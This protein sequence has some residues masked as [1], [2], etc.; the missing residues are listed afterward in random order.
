[1]VSAVQL[2]DMVP[3]K[4]G[5]LIRTPSGLF[6]PLR[7]VG[8]VKVKLEFRIGEASLSIA[9]LRKMKPGAFIA[10]EDKPALTVDIFLNGSLIG[11]GELV[12]S[13]GV[14]GVRV[15]NFSAE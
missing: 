6:D 1:M 13:E 9:D 12:N 7:Y 5:E 8:D 3:E 10:M 2:K 11:V 4:E 14:L 15:V